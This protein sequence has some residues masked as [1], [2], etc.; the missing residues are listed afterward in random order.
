MRIILMA[1]PSMG[2][3]LLEALLKSGDEVMAVV[4]PGAD[5]L[6]PSPLRKVAT[7][8]G[9][10]LHEPS[11]MKDAGVHEI[12]S[13]YRPELGVLAFVQDI[14]P[15]P[16]LNLPRQGTIMYHPSLLPRHRGGSAINWTII[17]GETKTGVS[18]IWPDA[19][20]DTGPILLQKETDI[21]PDDTPAHSSLISSTRWGLRRSLRLFAW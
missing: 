11:R 7:G 17:Q 3:K 18:I 14:V 16:V 20:I 15:V 9:I 2:A 13:S 6:T 8:A 12:I 1:H 10:P 4:S 5:P 19:G 21:S